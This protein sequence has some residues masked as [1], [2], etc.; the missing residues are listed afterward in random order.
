MRRYAM[1]LLLTMVAGTAQAGVIYTPT[2]GAGC[3]D[4][5]KPQFGHWVCAGPG[6]YAVGFMDEGNIAGV[7]IG[8]GALAP[9]RLKSVSRFRGAKR[10]FG[11]KLEWHVSDGKVQS[12]VLRVWKISEREQDNERELQQLEVYAVGKGRT[13]LIATVDVA[14][15]DANARASMHAEQAARSPCIGP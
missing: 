5:S 14:Q 12:A 11:E 10:V 8:P 13:C 4:Y 2:T 6:G 9:N 15:S 3:R 1:V 7:A